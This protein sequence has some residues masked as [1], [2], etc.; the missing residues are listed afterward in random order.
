MTLSDP[1]KISARLLPALK[2]GDSWLSWDG[3]V[4]FLDTPPGDCITYVIDDFRPGAACN[5]QECF[6]AILSFMGAAAE[7]RQ[8]RDRTGQQGENEDL[9]PEPIVDWICANKDE[10]DM[11]AYDLEEGPQLIEGA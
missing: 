10:I 5:V 11:L 7:S 9:F 1:F 8:F 6:A 4:F 3:S 2:I